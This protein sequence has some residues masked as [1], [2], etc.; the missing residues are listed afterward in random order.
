MKNLEVEIDSST[1]SKMS[2][3][4]GEHVDQLFSDIQECLTSADMLKLWLMKKKSEMKYSYYHLDSF[5]ITRTI[6]KMACRKWIASCETK[7]RKIRW[8]SC[9]CPLVKLW[10]N[11]K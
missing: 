3:C 11:Y 1:N 10:K 6:L 8:Y 2:T 7:E 9:S 5:I 4:F